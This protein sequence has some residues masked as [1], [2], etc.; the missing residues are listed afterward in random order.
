[1]VTP[2][3]RL[4]VL[5]LSD[6]PGRGLHG[7]VTRLAVKLAAHVDLIVATGGG[8]AEEGVIGEVLKA[9]IRTVRLGCLGPEGPYRI[10]A[11][12]ELAGA[13]RREAVDVV[14]CHSFRY[15]PLCALAARLAH[16]Y[17][18]VVMTDHNSLG[19]RGLGR[20][21]R[22]ACLCACRP[23]LIELV[24]E[25]GDRS[26][27]SRAIRR[28]VEWIPNGVDTV[29]FQ[30]AV[31]P[32]RFGAEVRLVYPAR[33]H[34]LKG[35]ADLLEI[36]ASLRRTGLG[37][38]LTL[39]GEGPLRESLERAVDGLGLRG[40]VEF[41]GQL[42]RRD[43]V[44]ELGAADIGVFPSHSEMMPLALIEMMATGLPVVAYGAGAVGEVIRHG[45]T[46]F[47]AP[48]GSKEL[49]ERCLAGLATDAQAAREM[50]ARGARDI[51]DRFDIAAVALQT[52]ELYRE[53]VGKSAGQK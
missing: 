53:I 41:K 13:L 21:S 23:F 51:A 48:V 36:C 33:L 4:R 43:L 30:C 6:L 32:P 22:L 26:N 17:P 11:L 29:V 27:N 19:W 40:A 52:A 35:H 44:K 47:V 10:G 16:P 18:S 28:R 42:P 38:R 14:H 3:A 9:G 31:R 39:A 12:R 8:E 37:I 46:G 20:L 25:H 24:R 50:G 2:S 34:A 5:Y 7:G 1:M 15:V 45:E 49:F